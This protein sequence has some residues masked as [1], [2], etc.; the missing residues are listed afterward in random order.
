MHDSGG[1]SFIQAMKEANSTAVTPGGEMPYDA[2]KI[3]LVCRDY[4]AT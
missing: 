2:K 4:K 3:P 1:H